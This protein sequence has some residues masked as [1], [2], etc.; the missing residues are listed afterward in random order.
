MPRERGFILATTLLVMTLLTVMLTAAFV[1]VSAESRTTNA[2]YATTRSLGLAQAGLQ[3]YLSQSHVLGSG[4]DSLNYAFPGG[5]SRVVARRLRDSTG[6]ERAVWVVYSTGVDSTGTLVG[7]GS[8]QRVVAQLAHL[9]AGILPARAAMVA[10]NGV[11]MSASGANPI[12]GINTGFD[13]PPCFTPNPPNAFYDTVGLVTGTG[14]YTGSGGATPGGEAGGTQYLADA[15]EVIDSTR[16]DWARLVA[17]EFTPD[18]YN[19]LP[20]NGNSTYQSHYFTG[21]VTIPSGTRR[22]MLVSLGNVTLANGSHW[23]GIIIAGGKLDANV[24]GNFRVHGIVITGLNISLGQAVSA[25]QVRRECG[26]CTREIRWDY[27]YTR[28]SI[29]NLSYLVPIRGTFV[30]TWKTY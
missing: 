25:N 27:C 20:T 26:T 12:D 3:S 7:Q 28:S 23:D 2:S 30:D 16:I 15:G 10:A 24:N 11:S 6:T 5:Y 29:A 21:N 18:S 4:Y 14:M 17:G 1:M 22:G 13:V 8:G 9:D 19:A